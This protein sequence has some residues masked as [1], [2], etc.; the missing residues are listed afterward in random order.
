MSRFSQAFP[1]ICSVLISCHCRIWSLLSNLATYRELL[2]F[3]FLS[4]LHTL[5]NIQ[6]FLY[7]CWF[8][9]RHIWDTLKPLLLQKANGKVTSNSDARQCLWCALHGMKIQRTTKKAK[10]FLIIPFNILNINDWHIAI[11]QYLFSTV[12]YNTHRKKRSFHNQDQVQNS[13]KFLL[14][15]KKTKVSHKYHSSKTQVILSDLVLNSVSQK[16]NPT[17]LHSEQKK[18]T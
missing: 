12:I 11:F 17:L 1:C 10:K 18:T 7:C 9:R 8:T 4:E 5:L 14:K 3:F 6:C 16:K 15:Y 2:L 13:S